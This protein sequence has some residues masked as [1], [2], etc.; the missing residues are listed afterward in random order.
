[1]GVR[2]GKLARSPRLFIPLSIEPSAVLSGAAI[3]YL[4]DQKG[5]GAALVNVLVMDAIRRKQEL[6]A[7]TCEPLRRFHR[8]SGTSHRSGCTCPRRG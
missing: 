2:G 5:I 8:L 1:M 6:V 7:L 4:A 3:T